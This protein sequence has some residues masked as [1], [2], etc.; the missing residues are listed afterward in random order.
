MPEAATAQFTIKGADGEAQD[1]GYRVFI[2]TALKGY[3][4][5]VSMPI[6][7]PGG[8]VKVTLRGEE[9]TIK[10]AVTELRKTKPDVKKVGKIEISDPVFGSFDFKPYSNDDIQLLTLNQLSKGIP[11]II[12]M[13]EKVEEIG[14]DIGD[15]K[16][17]VTGLNNK[18]H[19]IS[20]TLNYQLIGIV[21]LVLMA[22]C[23]LLILVS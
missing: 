20:R 4:L 9:K 15:M 13:D 17:V 10:D 23:A 3:G 6:N 12:R 7:I 8:G 16:G 21:L 14:G 1:V 18:Y 5:D 11:A 2:L 22:L 19:V